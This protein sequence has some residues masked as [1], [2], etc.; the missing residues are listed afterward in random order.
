ASAPTLPPKA[1]NPHDNPPSILEGSENATRSQLAHVL[2]RDLL[3][4][5][6]IPA[7]WI[8]MKMLVVSSISRGAG[9]HMRL[10][11]KHWDPRLM[12][13]AQALQNEVMADAVRF[14]PQASQWLHGISWQLEMA[15]SCPYTTLPD[16]KFW[17]DETAKLAAPMMAAA[18]VAAVAPVAQ[19]LTARQAAEADDAEEDL[20][21]LFFIRDQ[22]LERSSGDHAPDGYE[23]TQPSPL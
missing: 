19:A 20:N 15:D 7:Q 10:I 5:H 4:R 17:L 11:V 22:E 6:G 16:K 21:R 18:P 1:E 2:L 8:D 9:L 23:S 14:D 3:R 13:Y 12:H